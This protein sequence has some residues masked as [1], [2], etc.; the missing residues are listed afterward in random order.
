MICTLPL[1]FGLLQATPWECSHWPKAVEPREI[2]AEAQRKDGRDALNCLFDDDTAWNRVL[3]AIDTGKPEWLDVARALLPRADG[4]PAEDLRVS[5]SAALVR[6]PLL[7]LRVIRGEE[8]SVCG[9]IEGTRTKNEALAHLRSQR[10]A[11]LGVSDSDLH[12]VR[13][14]CLAAIERSR[15]EDIPRAGFPK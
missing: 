14:V 5:L 1:L 8:A 12:S 10:E 4:G 7:T 13:E 2:L 15:L 6:S 3:C 9:N 11:V